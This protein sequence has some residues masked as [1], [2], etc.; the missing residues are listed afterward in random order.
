MFW[1]LRELYSPGAYSVQAH[2][3]SGAKAGR[4]T[5][6]PTATSY[7]TKVMCGWLWLSFSEFANFW[8]LILERGTHREVEQNAEAPCVPPACC[9]P[10][11]TSPP[12][13]LMWQ[14]EMYYFIF[15]YL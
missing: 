9:S 6:Y 1:S 13:V 4:Q 3:G 11:S 12:S 15:K 10:A 14:I 7:P 8:E 2:S 5:S